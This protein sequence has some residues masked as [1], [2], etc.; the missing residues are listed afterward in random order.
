MSFLTAQ[1]TI[2]RTKV[3]DQLKNIQRVCN[4]RVSNQDDGNI[5]FP[6]PS[7]ALLIQVPDVTRVM[8]KLMTGGYS[9]T[10]YT[11]DI[12]LRPSEH[13]PGEMLAKVG[14][15]GVTTRRQENYVGWSY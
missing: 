3:A 13:K 10:P 2:K 8:G 14:M 12:P 7:L 5:R 15:E 6:P 1:I 4:S 9:R 11:A